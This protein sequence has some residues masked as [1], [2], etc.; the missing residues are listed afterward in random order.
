MG[1]RNKSAI[2]AELVASRVEK[3]YVIKMFDTR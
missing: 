1:K 2:F 3:D